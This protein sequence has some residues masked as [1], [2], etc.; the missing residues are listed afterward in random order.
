M[1]FGD[2]ASALI[3]S[4]S[5]RKGALEIVDVYLA[6]DGQYVDDLGIRCPGSEY[7]EGQESQ[8]RE[9]R[10]VGQ[11]VILQASRRMIG[12]CKTVLERNDQEVSDLRW[13]VPH[14]ANANLLNQVARGIGLTNCD[15]VISVIEHTGNTSSASMGLALDHL[16]RKCEVREGDYVLLPAFAAGFTWGAALCRAV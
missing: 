8:D 4:A 12:A 2:A 14:Q 10:M 9:P 3:I 15:K 7:G 5:P 16:L 6:T 11:S 13:I 1:L